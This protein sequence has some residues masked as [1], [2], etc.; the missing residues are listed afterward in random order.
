MVH[1]DKDLAQAAADR[2]L[3]VQRVLVLQTLGASLAGIGTIVLDAAGAAAKT[4]LNDSPM[5]FVM[6]ATGADIGA[7]TRTGARTKARASSRARIRTKAKARTKTRARARIRTRLTEKNVEA[8][9]G[10]R[11]PPVAA[12]RAQHLT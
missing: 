6:S 9:R 4:A 1:G 8:E 3:E 2:R 7:V 5:A 11:T 10:R 12:A